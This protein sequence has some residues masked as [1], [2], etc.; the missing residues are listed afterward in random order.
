MFKLNLMNVD[1]SLLGGRPNI[2]VRVRAELIFYI[3]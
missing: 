2:I 1:Y 3:A